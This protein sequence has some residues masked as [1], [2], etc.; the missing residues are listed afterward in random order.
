M[1][2]RTQ[3]TKSIINIARFIL[4]L[5]L[6]I[7]FYAVVIMVIINLSTFAYKFSYRIFGNV[8]VEASPGH[9]VKIQIKKGDGT[10]D[11]AKRLDR[12]SIIIDKYSFYI[13]AK[14]ANKVIKPG[15]YIVNTSMNYNQ[16]F[17]VITGVVKDKSSKSSEDE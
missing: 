4:H 2:E 16:I 5:F 1:A 9:D 6:N 11:I 8:A 15:S 13:K 12:D 10:L 7:L 14:L 17:D 3:K